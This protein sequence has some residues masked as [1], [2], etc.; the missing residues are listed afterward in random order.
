MQM[1]PAKAKPRKQASPRHGLPNILVYFSAL[2]PS[3]GKGCTG[4]NRPSF[5]LSWGSIRR[6]PH[7]PPFLVS[8][9]CFHYHNLWFHFTLHSPFA[10][11]LKPEPPPKPA[12]RL[13][14][15]TYYTRIQHDQASSPSSPSLFVILA[16]SVTDRPRY[17]NTVFITNATFLRFTIFA[18]STAFSCRPNRGKNRTRS[19]WEKLKPVQSCTPQTQ[20][21]GHH[22][23]SLAKALL[24]MLHVARLPHRTTHPML[25]WSRAVSWF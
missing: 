16:L 1:R 9:A 10:L 18:S 22:S 17:V 12:D 7:L 3:I 25:L 14:S 5:L 8:S 15:P 24:L 11:L 19:T 4:Q 20:T 2:A 23:C 13:L 6:T 21:F